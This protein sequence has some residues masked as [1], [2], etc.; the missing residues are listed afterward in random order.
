MEAPSD[1]NL[2]SSGQAQ[3][4]GRPCYNFERDGGSAQKK[5]L[6]QTILGNATKRFNLDMV[7]TFNHWTVR[8]RKPRILLWVKKCPFQNPGWVHRAR[9]DLSFCGARTIFRDASEHPCSNCQRPPGLILTDGSHPYVYPLRQGCPGT[10]GLDRSQSHDYE[11][12]TMVPCQVGIASIS[13]QRNV[14]EPTRPG[15]S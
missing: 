2:P 3:N 1:P 14:R 9:R 15:E 5:Q 11:Q 7:T 8:A 6:T 13:K 12:V 10:L 4:L